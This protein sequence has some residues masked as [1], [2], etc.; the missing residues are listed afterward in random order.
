MLVSSTH[1]SCSPTPGG[2]DFSHVIRD[3]LYNATM[4]SSTP[5]IVGCSSVSIL[6]DEIAF[7]GNETFLV[8]VFATSHENAQI[9]N[10]SAAYV[11]VLDNDRKWVWH[12]VT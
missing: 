7:E 10:S 6:D 2:V 9:G 11:I 8:Q 5:P 4:T 12:S 1:V 3:V